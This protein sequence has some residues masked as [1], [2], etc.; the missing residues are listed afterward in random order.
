MKRSIAAIHRGPL[1]PAWHRQGDDARDL[2]AKRSQCHAQRELE[3][4]HPVSR[5]PWGSALPLPPMAGIT[6]PN[7]DRP[8]TQTGDE[9][10]SVHTSPRRCRHDDD[11]VDR[12]RTGGATGREDIVVVTG[13][14]PSERRVTAAWQ[15]R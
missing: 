8:T 9:H 4:P 7:T 13:H 5:L 15:H 6:A 3:S 2:T 14:D 1:V 12:K 10:Q 11:G